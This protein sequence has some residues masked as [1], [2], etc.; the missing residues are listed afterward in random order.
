MC[1]CLVFVTFVLETC[2]KTDELSLRRNAYQFVA[3]HSAG[4]GQDNEG[5]RLVRA[6]P[7]PP[8]AHDSLSLP[9]GCHRILPVIST[10]PGRERA[11]KKVARLLTPAWRLERRLF[12]IASHFRILK[13][14]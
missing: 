7:L 13:R 6:A 11:H 10:T 5:D 8:Q 2:V 9:S 12:C 4:S 3:L 1:I 14:T